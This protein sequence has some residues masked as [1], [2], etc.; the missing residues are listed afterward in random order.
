ML[1]E[2]AVSATRKDR[3]YTASLEKQSGDLSKTSIAQKPGVNVGQVNIY[4]I[5]EA[6]IPGAR[7][8]V[9]NQQ[10]MMGGSAATV[11]AKFPKSLCSFPSHF[12]STH[13]ALCH[14]EIKI[15]MANGQHR[16]R[17]LPSGKITKTSTNEYPA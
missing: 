17:P 16:S 9:T 15:R 5:R 7:S 6:G 13:S 11:C 10:S 14:P 12:C 8:A 1:K 4:T 3:A 2:R